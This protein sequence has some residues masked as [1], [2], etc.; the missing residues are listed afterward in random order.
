VAE[1]QPSL[2]HRVS[3]FNRNRKW[4]IFQTKILPR[5]ELKVLDV[6]FNSIEYSHID[7][8]IE[9]HYPYPEQLTALGLDSPEQFQ[10]RYP[11]VRAV[12]YDGF[13]FPF[14]DAEFDVC[15]SN[16]VIEH[17]GDFDRQLLFLQETRRVAKRAFITTPNRL[18]PIEV[19]TRTPL[20]HWL[21]KPMF[22]SY[23]RWTGQQYFAG[24]YMNL[25]TCAQLKA[26]L[27]A[28]GIDRYEIV[29]N[30][31]FGC[32]LDFVVIF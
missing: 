5:P 24:G 1:E 17:V 32:T 27:A 2:A 20:L 7:N 31:L 10:K 8:Y 26:L 4:Q 18:F 3:A 28:A 25:L 16:A 29:R 13:R 14:G 9:K 12:Q 6:G 22:D 23:L 15:W 11:R 21:P 30:R 19:H